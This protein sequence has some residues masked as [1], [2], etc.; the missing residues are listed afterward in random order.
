[1]SGTGYD[2]YVTTFSPDGKIFQVEY[3]VKAVETSET[4]IGVVCK[5]GVILGSEKLR[6]TDL[7][8]ENTNPKNFTIDKKI[9][10]SIGGRLPDGKNIVNRARDEAKGYRQN[11]GIDING[12]TL[13]ERIGQYVHMH[14]LY[15]AYRPFG[16]NVMIASADSDGYKLHMVEPSGSFLGYYGC[17]SGKG[18]TIAKGELDKRNF[19]ELTCREALFHIAKILHKTHEEF[20]DKKFELDLTW[21]CKESNDEHTRVPE[22]L[23]REAEE[24][25]KKAIEEEEMGV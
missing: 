9:G 10:M 11:Y 1:M 14:T 19:R 20:K 24:K 7:I 2:L 13:T 3:A 4:T 25:A 8:V 15:F 18:K 17:A 21:I 6:I 5:D 16:C 23:Q 22:D 12:T